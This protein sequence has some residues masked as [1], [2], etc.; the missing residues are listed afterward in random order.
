MSLTFTIAFYYFLYF[1]ISLLLLLLQLLL[2][3]LLIVRLEFIFRAHSSTRCIFCVIYK[4]YFGADLCGSLFCCPSNGQPRDEDG[5]ISGSRFP[6]IGILSVFFIL[7]DT[8]LLVFFFIYFIFLS[9][10]SNTSYSF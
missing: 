3:F 8:R 4:T 10:I 1:Y 7:I 9:I 6:C 5:H 2:F